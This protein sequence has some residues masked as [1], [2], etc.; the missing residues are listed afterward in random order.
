MK[1]IA[2]A[3]DNG[4]VAG[5]FG[6]CEA[7]IVFHAEDKEIVNVEAIASPGHRPGF[8]PVFLA[9]QGVNVII[10]GGMGGSAV[11]L[12]NENNIEVIIGAQGAAREVAEAY[13][14]GLLQS[15]GS[16][17]REHQHHDECGAHGE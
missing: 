1:K 4:H 13:L 16:I 9:E 17:C 12:F 14:N 11:S 5:H 2:V 15:T 8:L 7:F 6:H 3:S 10:S